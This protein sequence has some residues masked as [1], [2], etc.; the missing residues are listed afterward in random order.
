M[1]LA[2]AW[3]STP[4]W[5][6]D[7]QFWPTVSVYTPTAGGWRASAE[8]HVRWTDDLSTYDRT[9]YRL[10]GGRLLP[11]GLEV[12][13]G[14]E[15]IQPG[16]AAVPS[17][18]RLWEQVE[19][20]L[21]RGRWSFANRVRLEERFIEHA[22][23]TAARL[24]YRF[25]VQHPLGRTPWT[26]SAGEELWL[27]LNTVRFA[28]TS[29]VEQN[30]IT[31]SAARALSRHLSVEPGYLRIHANVPQPFRDRAAHVMTMQVTVRF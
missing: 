5:A 29:G 16:T 2:A 15:K 22:D 14:Y 28:G 11:H 31:V 1:L 10:N 20:T 7:V 26:V 27:R 25:R 18:Q 9:V 23:G 30:R 17:E 12:F 24:R 4:A 6:D 8:V 19:H 13:V 21:R 3:R